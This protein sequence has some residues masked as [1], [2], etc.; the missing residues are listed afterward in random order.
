MHI[1]ETL[2]RHE[3]AQDC[4]RRE[5][6][7]TGQPGP[8][9][10]QLWLPEGRTFP[11]HNQKTCE[12]FCSLY[13]GLGLFQTRT[14]LKFASIAEH[15]SKDLK[16]FCGSSPREKGESG[17]VRPYAQGSRGKNRKKRKEKQKGD[18][19]PLFLRPASQMRFGYTRIPLLFLIQFCQLQP[20]Q[21]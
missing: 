1:K 19:V 4:W 10:C 16:P 8:V 18:L 6:I 17:K 9:G 21:V 20:K 7:W 15:L 12:C 2:Q 14:Q 11:A 3:E 5:S 13:R